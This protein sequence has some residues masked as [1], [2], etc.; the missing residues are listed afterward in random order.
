MSTYSNSKLECF[1]C[2]PLRYRYAYI[3]K[4]E[5][6][7]EETVEQFLGKSLRN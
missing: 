7:Y 3:D 6:P 2:C 5:K 1:E 4:I